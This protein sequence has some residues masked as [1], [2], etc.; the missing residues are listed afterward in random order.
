MQW[1][2][3]H[4]ATLIAAISG[5]LVSGG[6]VG[7]WIKQKF[8][9]QQRLLEQLAAAAVPASVMTVDAM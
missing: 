9:F 6:V 8:S 2:I 7:W 1:I 4:Q 3:E 5:A